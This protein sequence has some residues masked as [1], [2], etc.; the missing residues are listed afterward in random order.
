MSS[1]SRGRIVRRWMWL[2][3]FLVLVACGQVAP[4][5][6][7]AAIPPGWQPLQ[8]KGLTL[9]LPPAWQVITSE[10]YEVGSSLDSLASTNSQLRP[11]LDR[12]KQLF[13][14]GQVQLMAFDLDPAQLGP[15]FT[16]NLTLGIVPAQGASLTQIRAANTAQLRATPDFT[17]LSDSDS[18]VAGLPSVEFGYTLKLQDAGGAVKPLQVDQYLWLANDT[19]YVATFTTT[20]TQT[21]T[22]KPTFRHVL[23]T[24]RMTK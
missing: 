7:A 2:G 6:T 11:T 10:Q 24:V 4:T 21:T 5:L 1:I 3:L 18:K 17:N 19:Q 12:A 8:Q 13:S 16:T 22:L 23:D 9:A 20:P 15:G 14:T